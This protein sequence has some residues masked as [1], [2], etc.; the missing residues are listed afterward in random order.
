MENKEKIVEIKENGV[1]TKYRGIRK[2]KDL[3][4]GEIVEMEYAEKKVKHS[5]KRGWRRVYL[6]QFMEVLTGLYNQGKK[7]KVVEF[8][9]ENLNDLNQFTQTQNF[10]CEKLNFSPATVNKAFKYLIEI[11]FMRKIGTVYTINPKF[12]CAFGSD[13]KNATIAIKYEEDDPTLFDDLNN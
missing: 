3:E 13:K 2:F 5:L 6:E 12:V 7:I 11:N 9:L 10:I 8:L 1:V 4:T